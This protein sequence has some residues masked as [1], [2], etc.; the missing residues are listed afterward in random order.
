M[1]TGVHRT[2]ALRVD[3]FAAPRGKPSKMKMNFFSDEFLCK[4]TF[5]HFAYAPK[6]VILG[7]NYHVGS[8]A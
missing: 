1:K 3:V 6:E 8:L 2:T 7:G 4:Y 5:I